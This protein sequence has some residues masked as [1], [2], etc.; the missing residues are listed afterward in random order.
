MKRS[1]PQSYSVNYLCLIQNLFKQQIMKIILKTCFI[2][3]FFFLVIAGCK[4]D[5]DPDDTF[6]IEDYYGKYSVTLI[7]NALAENGWVISDKPVT[8]KIATEITLS[9]IKET[10]NGVMVYVSAYG[11]SIHTRF[12]PDT[13]HLVITDTPYSFYLRL[14]DFPKFD[15]NYEVAVFTFGYFVEWDDE[16]DLRLDFCFLK[17]LNDSIFICGTIAKKTN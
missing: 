11:D 7:V 8:R 4:K 10:Q 3:F 16:K 6:K 5:K 14:N 2:T 9:P 12:N 17:D 15:G 13:K 1:P